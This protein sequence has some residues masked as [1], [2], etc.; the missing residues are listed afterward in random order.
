MSI[1]LSEVP[2]FVRSLKG[3]SE[4]CVNPSKHFQKTLEYG[5]K[6]GG[7]TTNNPELFI[8]PPV[9]CAHSTPPKLKDWRSKNRDE[10]E[11]KPHASNVAYLHKRNYGSQVS[12]MTTVS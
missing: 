2:I 1:E 11:D 5:K 7:C 3:D 9:F 10:E 6:M 4:V 12:K 8:P